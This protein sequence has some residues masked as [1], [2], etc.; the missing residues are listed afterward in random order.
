MAQKTTKAK[1]S[2]NPVKA[3]KPV[4]VRAARQS[5]SDSAT[6]YE[7]GVEMVG[8]DGN[9]WIIKADKNGRN[10]WKKRNHGGDTKSCVVVSSTS[11]SGMITKI[12]K[13]EWHSDLKV[14]KNKF[15]C[16]SYGTDDE[17]ESTS[18][19]DSSALFFFDGPPDAEPEGVS[20]AVA[21]DVAEEADGGGGGSNPCTNIGLLYVDFPVGAI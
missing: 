6:S 8:N 2:T 21:E 9:L 12:T 5:P 19:T 18:F 10:S 1:A 4:K 16:G 20:D 17:E 13:G 11:A 15:I 14:E 3:S 7:V